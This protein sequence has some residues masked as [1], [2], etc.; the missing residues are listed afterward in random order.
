MATVTDDPL[1]KK[2]EMTNWEKASV[3]EIVPTCIDADRLTRVIT[4]ITSAFFLSCF[5]KIITPSRT[6]SKM[7]PE[8][9]LIALSV[10]ENV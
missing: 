8:H 2:V 9:A 1:S 3:P 6:L 10:Q 5:A 4:S 7:A